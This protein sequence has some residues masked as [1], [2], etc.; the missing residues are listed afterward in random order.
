M[1]YQLGNVDYCGISKAY[2]MS[3]YHNLNYLKYELLFTYLII[4][5][6]IIFMSYYL[7][8]KIT[9]LI[10]QL[11][12]HIKDYNFKVKADSH[13]RISN[14][15][16][17]AILTRRFNELIKRINDAFSYQKHAIHHISHELK[18]PI[19]IPGSNFEKIEKET[20]RQKMLERIRV[21]KEQT[22]SLSE[23]INYLLEVAKNRIWQCT[24]AYTTAC[25]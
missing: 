19:A 10:V 9:N 1:H 22:M 3:S 14:K 15:D 8:R 20:D 17:V 13:A 21:Q 24:A 18:T 23:I 2:D 5:I 4:L 25:R 12:S 6:V 7:S 11:T 16:E